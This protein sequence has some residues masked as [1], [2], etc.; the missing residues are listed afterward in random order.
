MEPE[1]VAVAFEYIDA[2]RRDRVGVD[3]EISAR[4]FEEVAVV[5]PVS[6]RAKREALRI[7]AV[8][9]GAKR[10]LDRTLRCESERGLADGG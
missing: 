1:G 3:R 6:F 2:C 5:I 4:R 10:W 7:R 9:L 8:D